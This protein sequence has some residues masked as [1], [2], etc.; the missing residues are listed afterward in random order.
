[1][2]QMNEWHLVYR[3]VHRVLY[4]CVRNN[5]LAAQYHVYEY[6]MQSR[7]GWIL[8]NNDFRPTVNLNECEQT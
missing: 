2:T 6:C 1:M 4:K 8:D 3:L 7:T 5:L